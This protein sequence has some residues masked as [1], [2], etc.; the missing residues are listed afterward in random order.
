[1]ALQARTTT[2]I[3][4]VMVLAVKAAYKTNEEITRINSP[5]TPA[6][7]E[8]KLGKYKAKIHHE[9]EDHRIAEIVVV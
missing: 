3:A 6:D 7:T 4:N 8:S 9:I 2:R 5:D 1:M